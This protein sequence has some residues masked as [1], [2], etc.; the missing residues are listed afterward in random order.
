MNTWLYD[1]YL[2]KPDCTLANVFLSK[3]DDDMLGELLAEV[4]A[5]TIPPHE[6]ARFIQIGGQWLEYPEFIPPQQVDEM[7]T[8]IKRLLRLGRA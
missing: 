4:R 2:A 3:E 8:E 6:L 7:R 5:G 1:E